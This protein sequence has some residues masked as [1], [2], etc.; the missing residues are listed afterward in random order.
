MF[1]SSF[2]M[3][4]VGR[5]RPHNEDNFFVDNDNKIYIVCDGMGGANAGEVASRMAVD[6]ISARMRERIDEIR[7]LSSENTFDS[8]QKIKTIISDAVSEASLKIFEIASREES[9]KGMGTTLVML[10]ICGE[11][12]FVSNVGDSRAYLIRDNQVYQITEDHTLVQEQLKR[13]LITPEEAKNVTYGNVITR[14]VGVME[15]VM[16]DTT[17]IELMAG[18]IFLLCTDG[19]HGYTEDKDVLS[20]ITCSTLEE[21]ANCAIEFANRSG[22]KDNITAIFV[23]VSTELKTEVPASDKINLLKSVRLFKYCSYQ[24]IMKVLSVAT[25]ETFEKDE[26]IL[27]ENEPGEEFY[28]I[29]SGEVLVKSNSKPIATLGVGKHFGEMSLIDLAPRSASVVTTQPSKLIKIKRKDFVALIK[30]DTHLGIK[31]LWS[32]L[33]DLSDRLRITNIELIKHLSQ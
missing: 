7:E 5:K 30:E 12:A 6:I 32:F 31:L 4:D 28:I 13:G 3:T 25:I 21:M 15:S 19:L 9:K 33:Q 29:L 18:D 11:N 2:G 20:F 27:M 10:I 14:A 8:K 26:I 16:V 23:R 17:H 24:E 1:I 22:G